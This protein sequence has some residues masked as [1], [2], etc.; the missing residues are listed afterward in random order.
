VIP[1]CAPGETRRVVG[2][3]SFYEGQDI[4]AELARIDATDW[5]EWQSGTNPCA[6][7]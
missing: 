4:D 3:L 1:D 2:R 6:D 7:R 5:R